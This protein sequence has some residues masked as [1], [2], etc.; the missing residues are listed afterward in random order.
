MCSMFLCVSKIRKIPLAII[1][2]LLILFYSCSSDTCK[3]YVSD[4][5]S[6]SFCHG[7]A[8][9][10]ERDLTPTYFDLAS[11]GPIQ[12][13]FIFSDPVPFAEKLVSIDIKLFAKDEKT[14]DFTKEI[15]LSKSK[16]KTEYWDGKGSK[17][18]SKV[19]FKENLFT[20]VGPEMKDYPYRETS[21]V[22]YTFDNEYAA[23]EYPE[24][25]RQVITIKW[26]DKEKTF[27]NLLS[28][29]CSGKSFISG[30]PF[31]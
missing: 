23:K 26:T 30:R 19:N 8:D 24:T 4:T 3:Y 28:K 7:G 6:L 5:G 25:L 17:E 18:A 20:L 11:E 22:T 1:S 13:Y 21:Y 27:T 10:V 29:S 14:N 16:L 2:G 12:V 15:T 31:G 9:S